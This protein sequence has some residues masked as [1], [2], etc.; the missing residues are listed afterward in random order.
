MEIP[1]NNYSKFCSWIIIGASIPLL[2]AI[3]L[4]SLNGPFV[5]DDYPNI[6]QASQLHLNHFSLDQFIAGANQGLIKN[7]PIAYF[8][9]ALNH[10]IGGLNPIG[11]RLFNLVLHWGVAVL[12]FIL[13]RLTLNLVQ[14]GPLTQAAAKPA[15]EDRGVDVWVSLL[16][17]LVWAIHPVHTQSVSY[18][19][20]RMTVLSAFFYLLSLFCYAKGRIASERTPRIAFFVSCIAMGLLALLSKENAL[21]LPVFIFLYEWF[22]FQGLSWRWITKQVWWIA[23]AVI[24]VFLVGIY[25]TNGEPISVILNS[26]AKRDFTLI[27]RLLTQSRVVWFY[28]SLIV[29][30][31]PSRLNFD[32][33]FIISHSITDPITTLFSLA[34]IAGLTIAAIIAAK[35]YPLVAFSI[36]WFLGNLVIE[37]SVLGLEMVFEHRIYLPSM[38]IVVVLLYY[39][40]GW[41]KNHR[42]VL[43]ICFATA[44]VIFSFWTHQRNHVWS[45]EVLLWN[46]VIV[47]S[48]EKARPWYNLGVALS[49]RQWSEPAI[50]V[51]EKAVTFDPD[52]AMIQNNL[53]HEYL[54]TG[55]DDKALIHLQKALQLKPDVEE[56]YLNLSKLYL[57]QDNVTEASEILLQ[58]LQ[59]APQSFTLNAKLGEIFLRNGQYTDAAKYLANAVSI[60]PKKIGTLNNFGVALISIGERD[61]AISIFKEVLRLDPDNPD[62]MRNLQVAGGRDG[63]E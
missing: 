15:S 22:F 41:L 33:D 38:F 35:R 47:K 31:N 59:K 54:V 42:I 37:S 20:Q 7:R 17:V 23:L 16:C 39:L 44:I 25:Y 56:A 40:I 28:I 14:G 27:E 11:Y 58:G 6:L 32:H 30:P 48:P 3:Y 19:V 62:A 46:D 5:F 21:M 1:K 9:F 26:Y 10:L 18:I 61:R 4:P 63:F 50:K 53:G 51:F 60:N 24:V 13:M 29:F 45:D 57:R 34:G 36:F 55:N 49:E 43:T 52:N 12:L 8:T 2:F